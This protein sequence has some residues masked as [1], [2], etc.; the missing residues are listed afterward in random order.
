VSAVPVRVACPFCGLVCDD[1]IVD[2][3]RVDTR[4]CAKAAANFSRRVTTSEHRIAGRAASLDD[5]VAAAA[6][7]LRG[8]RQPL[9][10][11][12]GADLSGMR[13]L[14]ALA[15]RLG[16]VVDRWRSAPQFANFA[17]LQRA[18]MLAATFAEIANRTDL[19]LIVGSDPA[20]SYPRFFERLL[21]NATPLYRKAAPSVVY[22]GPNV[23]A[24][25][26]PAVGERITVEGD[27]LPDALRALAAVIE[28]RR[29]AADPD[30]KL[31]AL[32][33]LARRLESASYGTIIWDAAELPALAREDIASLILQVLRV[34]TRKTR[35]VGLPLGGN[36][37]AQGVAQA[38]LWQTG[39]PGRLSFATGM[40][41]HDPWLYDAERLLREGEVDVLL[42]VQA[43]GAEPPPATRVPAIALL[44]AD[45]A[46][47][48]PAAVE[49]R[50]GVPGLDHRGWVM[51]SDTVVALPL[52]EMRSAPLPS[53]ATVATAI[54]RRV[55]A[56]P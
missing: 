43:F 41:I 26:D 4:G 37:N 34:L 47:P 14:L 8:A 48:A 50:I 24:P 15:E 35:C 22:L 44:S 21:R 55:E 52:A 29:V 56:Q 13:A 30:V 38:M 20:R 9:V 5:A 17:V 27:R 40:P 45:V 49:I 25:S 1:L 2:G 31:A 16:A 28:G 3:E 54:H 51:R 33:A 23:A 11:G 36:D 6:A 19:A 53:V 18:G 42:W 46:P 10:T 32:V 12:L 7:L 39:W